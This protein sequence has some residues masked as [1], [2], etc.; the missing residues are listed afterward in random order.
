MLTII[1]ELSSA[2]LQISTMANLM[3]VGVPIMSFTLHYSE[4]LACVPLNDLE[5]AFMISN[6]Y[7]CPVEKGRVLNISCRISTN[8]VDT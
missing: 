5:H 8:E 2:N 1:D 3:M 7:K 4:W 6:Q